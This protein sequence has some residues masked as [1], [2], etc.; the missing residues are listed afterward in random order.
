ML[1]RSTLRTIGFV[2]WSSSRSI[3]QLSGLVI[4]NAPLLERLSVFS[5]I[6]RTSIRVIN[7]PKLTLLGYS[8]GGFCYKLVIGF[9]TLKVNSPLDVCSVFLIFSQLATAVFLLIFLIH[10]RCC[11]EIDSRK[12]DLASA[13]SE[14]LG[15]KIYRTKSG[16]SCRLP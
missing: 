12:L 6:C 13:H 11:A 10:V 5:P 4:E 3:F 16:R 7:A 8:S 15:T 9:I 14:D 1:F 2:C